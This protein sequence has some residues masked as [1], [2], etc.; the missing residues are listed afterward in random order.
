MG[1]ELGGGNP[2]GGTGGEGGPALVQVNSVGTWRKVGAVGQMP[3]TFRREPTG[4]AGG[5][6]PRIEGTRDVLP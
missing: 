4:F 2:T 6:D 5:S 1:S 3:G